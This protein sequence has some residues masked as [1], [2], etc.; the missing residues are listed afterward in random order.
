MVRRAVT[1]N[2]RKRHFCFTFCRKI[3]PFDHA[4]ES[5]FSGQIPTYSTVRFSGS[6]SLYELLSYNGDRSLKRQLAEC[7]ALYNYHGQHT[8]LIGNTAH[9]TL[10]KKLAALPARIMYPVIGVIAPKRSNQK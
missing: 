8:A 4:L 1:A 5:F 9:E 7:E 3:A 6:T 2:C 10:K